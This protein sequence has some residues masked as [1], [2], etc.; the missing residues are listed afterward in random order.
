MKIAAFA[1]ILLL[2]IP[3]ASATVGTY[4]DVLPTAAE[5][6]AG[7]SLRVCATETPDGQAT[8]THPDASTTMLTADSEACWTFTLEEGTQTLSWTV[9]AAPRS[10]SIA[11]WAPT[12]TDWT[13]WLNFA[14]LSFVLIMAMRNS[15]ILVGAFALIGVFAFALEVMPYDF[16]STLALLLVAISLEWVAGQ[17]KLSKK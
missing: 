6:R 17:W 3:V 2:A 4:A 7:S 5:Y 12:E 11:A 10:V 16:K 8:L 15:W 14:F 1:L 9:A 13:W